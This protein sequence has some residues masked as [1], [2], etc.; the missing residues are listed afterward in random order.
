[1]KTIPHP[2]GRCDCSRELELGHAAGRG[3]Q[4]EI[5]CVCGR[6]H[7]IEHGRAGWTVGAALTPEGSLP[8]SGF[9]RELR[10]AGDA[11]RYWFSFPLR[12]EI[13]LPVHV[14]FSRASRRAQV[15]AA[16]LKVFEVEGVTL[17]TEARRRWIAWWQA[18]APKATQGFRAMTAP[19]RV[20]RLP[21]L[22]PRRRIVALALR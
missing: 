10:Q 19:R 21:A 1:M 9:S 17:P 18:R 14:L 20:G 13:A 6:R 12:G 22:A 7:E 11:E 3:S 4:R 15:K 5:A 16:D 8:L 2:V